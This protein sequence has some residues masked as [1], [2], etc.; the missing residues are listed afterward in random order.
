[1]DTAAVLK[2]DDQQESLERNKIENDTQKARPKASF[3]L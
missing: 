1:M 3:L 2:A